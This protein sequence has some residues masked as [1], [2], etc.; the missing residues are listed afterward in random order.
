MR[1]GNNPP[2]IFWVTYI[3]W[4]C[5]TKPVIKRPGFARIGPEFVQLDPRPISHAPMGVQGPQ[6]A[7]KPR[8]S[9][10]RSRKSPEVGDQEPIFFAPHLFPTHIF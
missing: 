4:S 8:K 9:E 10:I 5:S 6:T 3:F 1:A 7:Q 2:A